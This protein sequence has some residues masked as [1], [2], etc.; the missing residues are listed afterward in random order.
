MQTGDRLQTTRDG[1]PLVRML[2]IRRTVFIDYAVAVK[3]DEFHHVAS[4]EMSAT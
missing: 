3:D 4:L 1:N 2:D